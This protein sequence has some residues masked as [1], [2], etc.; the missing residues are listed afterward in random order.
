MGRKAEASTVLDWAERVEREPRQSMQDADTALGELALRRLFLGDQPGCVRALNALL[1]LASGLQRKSSREYYTLQ[2]IDFIVAHGSLPPPEKTLTEKQ[3]TP[4]DRRLAAKLAYARDA[5][6]DPTLELRA[7]QP[8]TPPPTSPDYAGMARAAVSQLR[9]LDTLNVHQ[10][11][12]ALCDAIGHLDDADARAFFDEALTLVDQRKQRDFAVGWSYV[13]LARAV[14]HLDGAAAARALLARATEAAGAH[15]SMIL[16][17]LAL[18][19]A[20]IGD[21]DTALTLAHDTETRVAVLVRADKWPQL[22]QALGGI[23]DAEVAVKIA[24]SMATKIE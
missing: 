16:R 9:Q 22:Q 1:D 7:V 10:S 8:P 21:P 23:T 15:R 13:S 24:W 4:T 20:E 6:H 18:A 19:Y 17:E 11:T 5:L 12:A 2:V 3:K 14:H